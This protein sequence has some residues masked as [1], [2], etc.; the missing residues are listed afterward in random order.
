MQLTVPSS[1]IVRFAALIRAGG[2]V[3]D[4]ACGGGRHA[5]WLLDHGFVPT[6]VD[7]DTEYVGDL[8]GRAEIITMDLEAGGPW[9]FAGRR[10]DAVI[11]T[12][13]L[14]RP[15]FPHLIDSVAAPG[16]RA[17]VSDVHAGP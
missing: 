6:L 4:V 8:A 14:H 3:L 11:V 16:G 1:W 12:N 2:T 13:Y 17:A 7:R 10:F 9:P 5:R 15:L